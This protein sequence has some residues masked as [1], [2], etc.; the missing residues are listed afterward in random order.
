MSHPDQTSVRYD[1][2]LEQ[3]VQWS[4]ATALANRGSTP[5]RP[6]TLVRPIE[7]L[8]VQRNS[9]ELCK[10]TDTVLSM[11][12]DVSG[13]NCPRCDDLTDWGLAGHPQLVELRCQENPHI[14]GETLV[15]AS[16][17]SL[18]DVSECPN[19][20]GDYLL[21]LKG[22]TRLRCS[23]CPK[24]SEEDVKHLREHGVEVTL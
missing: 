12:P 18:L 16:K 7:V 3:S 4:H 22:L 9:D 5:L 13:I 20:E 24:V 6:I 2:W 10:D 1:G 11:F 14:T 21:R 19:V 23:G 17:L 15:E 8:A